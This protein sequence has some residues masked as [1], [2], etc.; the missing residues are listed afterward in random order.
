MDRSMDVKKGSGGAMHYYVAVGCSSQQLA[1]L[2]ELLTALQLQTGRLS[3]AIAC[4]SRDVLDEVVCALA[5]SGLF[6]IT[7]LH[8]DLTEKELDFHAGAFKHACAHLPSTQG[9]DT[10]HVGDHNQGTVPGARTNSHG[11]AGPGPPHTTAAAAGLSGTGIGGTDPNPRTG[12]GMAGRDSTGTSASRNIMREQGGGDN[13]HPQLSLALVFT[14]V[15]LKALPK[16]LITPGGLGVSLLVQ[17]ELPH[18]R[19]LLSRRVAAVFGIR[20]HRKQ[21]IISFTVAGQ[22]EQ[23]RAFQGFVAPGHIL[24][25]PVHVGDVF[26]G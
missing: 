15:C 14:D 2:M 6:S 21:I 20:G 8:S 23:F 25:M 5:A 17:Y 12:A 1:T 3:V 11:H 4:S 26:S 18:K 13:A 16:E 24:E 19:E 9:T 7:A 10:T 22:M